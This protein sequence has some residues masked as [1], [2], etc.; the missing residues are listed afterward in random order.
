MIAGTLEVQLLANIARLQQDMQQAQRVVGSAMSSISTAVGQA[1]AAFL[2]LG[3]TVGVGVFTEI[4]KGAIDAA[5]HMNDLSKSTGVAVEMLSGLRVAAKQS[6]GDLDSIAQSFNKLSQNIGKESERFK[7]LGVT[8][9]DPM[10]AF[11][12]LADV[13]ASLKDPQLRAAVAAEALGKAWAGAAPLLAEGGAKIQE[14]VD[15]GTKAS[16]MT[17][18][19]AELS[20]RFNDKLVLLTGSGGL[21]NSVLKQVLPQ[22]DNFADGMLRAKEQGEGF[23]NMLR[24]GFESMRKG[25]E[26]GQVEA[27]IAKFSDQVKALKEQQSSGKGRFF[28]LETMG[29][30][31]TTDDQIRAFTARLELLQHRRTEIMDQMDKDQAARNKTPMDAGDAARR[32]KSFVDYTKAL[33]EAQRE[34][35]KYDAALQ[36]LE[37]QLGKFQNMTEQQKV[38][39]MTE[40]GS[41][42]DL[43][44][45]HKAQ[46]IEVAKEIDLERTRLAVLEMNRV[47][48]EASTAALEARSAAI[49]DFHHAQQIAITDMAFETSLIGKNDAE[50]EKATAIRKIQLDGEQRAAEINAQEG[51][52]I[53]ARLSATRELYRLQQLAIDGISAEIDKKTEATQLNQKTLDQ[54]RFEITLIGMTN[55][56]RE[57]AIALHA[58]ELAGVKKTAEGYEAY[59]AQ[60]KDVIKAK[61]T[62]ETMKQAQV[63]LWQEVDRV[64]KD[65]F[66]SIFDAGK[67]TFTRLRDSLKNTL[68]ALLY[69]MTLRPF[70]INVVMQTAGAGVA[71]QVFG[72]SAANGQS[73]LSLLSNASS[74]YSGITGDS[75]IGRAAGYFGLGGGGATGAALLGST[76]ASAPAFG[77]GGLLFGGSGAG[78]GL[79]E[80][81]GFIGGGGA[82]IGAEG[83]AL[84]LSGGAGSALAAGGGAMAGLATVAPYLAAA[85]VIASMLMKKGPPPTTQ[86]SDYV[87]MFDQAGKA[88]DVSAHGS[89]MAEVF[90][91]SLQERYAQAARSFG[92]TPLDS[93]FAAGFN[94]REGKLHGFSVSGAAGS[95]HYGMDATEIP[96]SE[97]ALADE[98]AR[99]VMTALA[100]SDLP[101]FLK[102]YFDS[103][104]PTAMSAS[105]IDNALQFAASLKDLREQLTMTDLERAA[106]HVEELNKA[107]GS[108]VATVD[109]WKTAFVAAIDA[110]IKPEAVAQWQALGQALQQLADV[111][112][113]AAETVNQLSQAA[114]NFAAYS[115]VI[116]NL[117]SELRSAYQKQASDL[118]ATADRFR[119]FAVSLREFRNSLALGDLSPMSPEA[120]YAE[121]KRQFQDVSSR[122]AL[123]D[124][125][126]MGQLQSASQAFLEASKSYNSVNAQFAQDFDAVR[127]A[128]DRTASVADRQVNIA[129]TQL[130]QLRLQVTGLIDLN[131]TT[132]SIEELVRLIYQARTNATGGGNL[133]AGQ[134]L[135]MNKWLDTDIGGKVLHSPA[136]ASAILSPGASDI[137]IFGKN[138]DVFTGAQA[139]FFAQQALSRGDEIGLYQAL[140]TAGISLSSFDMLEG[141]SPGRAEQWATDHGLPVFAQGTPFVQ[142]DTLAFVHK[143]ERI[144]PAAENDGLASALNNVVT[145]LRSLRSDRKAGDRQTGEIGTQT[146]DELRGT[147]ASLHK[148]HRAARVASA[149]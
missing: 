35:K 39:R 37:N 93:Q 42:K 90:A 7:A 57:T 127:A 74:A 53:D 102:K 149:R 27:E 144:T 70:L 49:S 148:L 115:D 64:A 133:V 67:D 33:A 17:K 147:V 145:E 94:V 83:T 132:R 116:S 108:N 40:K 134:T 9:K 28:S 12:Q 73:P 131:D 16:Q 80:S 60:L 4:I 78:L 142:S 141:W 5:D 95:G 43:T 109:A 75:L 8:A 82:L 122:A 21:W 119:A 52:S 66:V 71:Q 139:Q 25:G 114:R 113:P 120:R 136:G 31:G 14:M 10:E 79:A 22:I 65:T 32:A 110:G 23:F 38:A 48:M 47:A 59:V 130:Q 3:A 6:G 44:E 58:L 11:K 129:E 45:A 56:E 54:M 103:L 126:A 100:G 117:Q 125:T 96:Y 46:L 2:S 41:L 29:L 62:T 106:K 26:L 138:G 36:A 135:G 81:A 86:V 128:L 84:G 98:A 76:A 121:A 92:A 104:V 61:D 34:Q 15:R 20:D 101:P 13:F 89:D 18:E 146:I 1:K 68:F 72:A 30:G 97:Q 112:P 140:Q 99:A 111:V 85:V 91:K 51:A 143:G 50:R 123:G 118:Q 19:L 87:S 105:D 77:A 124:P 137:T 88:S 69:Q 24:N 63:E 55:A 107:L